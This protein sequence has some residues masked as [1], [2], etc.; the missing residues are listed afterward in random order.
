MEYQLHLQITL[1]NESFYYYMLSVKNMQY[2][3]VITTFLIIKKID[4]RHNHQQKT[5]QVRLVSKRLKFKHD[6]LNLVNN[7]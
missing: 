3:T 1:N 4:K 6:E 2:P 5:V 7:Y